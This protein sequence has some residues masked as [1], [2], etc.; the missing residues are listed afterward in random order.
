MTKWWFIIS[1][2]ESLLDQLSN[3]WTVVKL[4]TNWSLEPVLAYTDMPQLQNSAPLTQSVN[5]ETL[6]TQPHTNVSDSSSSPTTHC[7]P[8]P[9]V[10]TTAVS[11]NANFVTYLINLCSRLCLLPVLLPRPQLIFS[12]HDWKM[13]QHYT[14]KTFLVYLLSNLSLFP[15]LPCLIVIQLS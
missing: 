14:C 9:N 7:I 4:Q 5:V 1:G 8:F 13:D 3:N 10:H 11:T 15:L 12:P 6:G 2:E